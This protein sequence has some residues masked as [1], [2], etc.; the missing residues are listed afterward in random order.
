MK[1]RKKVSHKVSQKVCLETRTK[2][3]QLVAVRGRE[4]ERRGEGER[5]RGALRGGGK[6]GRGG[7]RK[8]GREPVRRKCAHLLLNLSYTCFYIFPYI[9]FVYVCVIV[10]LYVF[11]YIHFYLAIVKMSMLACDSMYTH[12]HCNNPFLV[13][14]SGKGSNLRYRHVSTSRYGSAP[15]YHLQDL[16]YQS[17]QQLEPSVAP[18]QRASVRS[19][20]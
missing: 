10:W 12:V 4:R 3:E 2:M 14:V 19:Q 17:T 5:E 15:R 20:S 1:R 9:H 18:H 16:I 6:G 8:G 7:R 13:L 11:I